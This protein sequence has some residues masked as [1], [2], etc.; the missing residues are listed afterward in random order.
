LLKT[1]ASLVRGDTGVDNRPMAKVF[2][3]V[4][5]RQFATRREFK[6]SLAT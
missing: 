5:Y 4:G 2:R 3:S 6:I 1:G